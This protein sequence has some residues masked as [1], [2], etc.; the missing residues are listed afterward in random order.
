VAVEV[1]GKQGVWVKGI[2]AGD[3]RNGCLERIGGHLFLSDSGNR[4]YYDIKEQIA[5]QRLILC[6]F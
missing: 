3:G 1:G 6:G 2:G 4:L 5:S